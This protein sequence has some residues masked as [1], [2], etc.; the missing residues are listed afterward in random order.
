MFPGSPKDLDP[1]ISIYSLKDYDFTYSDNDDDANESG[2][3]DVENMYYVA[4]CQL[5]CLQRGTRTISD[6]NATAKKE[7]NPE[8]ALKDFRAIV[9]QEEEK[10]DWYVL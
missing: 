4:K 9:D 8:G 7:D 6:L 3:A 2:S 10:G 1:T 5:L